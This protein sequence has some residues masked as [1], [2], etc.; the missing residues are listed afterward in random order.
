MDLRDLL[1]VLFRHIRWVIGG[2]F[3]TFL[4][5][6]G[7]R[8]WTRADSW[9]ASETLLMRGS[10]FDSQSY[11]FN[12]QGDSSTT[13]A[14]PTI[15]E[16]TQL[17]SGKEARQQ[18]EEALR[19]ELPQYAGVV[20]SVTP[21][22]DNTID[23]S[24]EAPNQ[25]DALK[26]L[27]VVCTAY[28]AYDKANLTKHVE[29]RLDMIGRE[30]D[31][32]DINSLASLAIKLRDD[33][34]RAREEK[35]SGLGLKLPVEVDLKFRTDLLATLRSSFW[36][37]GQAER[38]A[39]E[40]LRLHKTRYDEGAAD[41]IDEMLPVPARVEPKPT[42]ENYELLKKQERLRADLGRLLRR[43]Q[44]EHPEVQKLRDQILGLQEEILQAT[45]GNPY[46]QVVLVDQI[47]LL[48]VNQDYLGELMEGESVNVK[49]LSEIKVKEDAA[50]LQEAEVAKRRARQ[51][52]LLKEK[53]EPKDMLQTL[54]EATAGQTRI[55]WELSTGLM[56]LLVSL[57]VGVASAYLLEYVNDRIRT[58][59]DVKTYMNLPTIGL[60]PEFRGVAHNLL[61][62]AI[63][64]PPYEYYNKLATFVEAAVQEKGRKILMITSAKEEEGKSS[65]CA[66]L[67]IALAQSGRRVAVIDADMRKGQ[68]AA[69]FSL[70]KDGG[71]STALT[72]PPGVPLPELLPTMVET[73]RVL[74]SGPVPVNPLLLLRGE[75]AANML[76]QLEHR[77]DLDLVLV[78]TPPLMGVIDAAVLASHGIP[79]ILVVQD[80]AVRRAEMNHVRS[81]LMRVN[82]DILGVIINRSRI[83]P[84]TYYYYSY[85]RYR[86]YTA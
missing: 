44:D 21:G 22:A 80:D 58:V 35:I 17:L 85:S 40:K 63:K 8:F 49:A 23:I 6:A 25:D 68:L 53:G 73:L 4:V 34:T 51:G 71:L 78:D 42:K 67:A 29:I 20:A 37:S 38:E 11:L 10:A 54:R 61:E 24:V 72:E 27:G 36:Q 52:E 48:K 46:D 62:V 1:R 60:I 14:P 47:A 16:R 41:Q 2:F 12:V 7:T 43:Y 82:A 50:A 76:E 13:P 28:R 26:I 86:G 70:P 64:S 56:F 83:E 45:R 9:Q 19:R 55:R 39:R 66:N 31:T 32:S 69:I 33:A 75:R 81:N 79:V 3:V 57:V 77:E 59:A 65:I 15:K 5:M 84:E 74:P 18:V 30:L